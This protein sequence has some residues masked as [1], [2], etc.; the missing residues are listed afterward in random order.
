[1][2]HTST[3]LRSKAQQCRQES[4]DSFERCD[5]D[6][7]LSQGAND[8]MA[9]VYATQADIVENGGKAVFT[10]LYDGNR[11]VIAKT[12]ETQYG[13]T[14]LLDESEVSQ[15]GRKFIPRGSA[16]RVQKQLGLCERPEMQQAGA[17]CG[18]WYSVHVYRKGDQ[19]GRESE[20]VE[21]EVA[22]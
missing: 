7:F 11:R 18:G 21:A 4:I 8:I 22:Q 5:T 19:W 2:T 16:S 12:I 10:G 1:M 17:K 20:V 9:R 13:W 14:W 15:Y 3:Q 6:G